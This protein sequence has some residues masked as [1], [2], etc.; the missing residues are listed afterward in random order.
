[1]KPTLPLSP[2][3]FGDFEAV[4]ARDLD[5]PAEQKSNR[6]RQSA[7]PKTEAPKTFASKIFNTYEFGYRR[8]SIE[9]PLRESY[10]FSDERISALRF[11]AGALNAAMQW[12]YKEYGSNWT[13]NARLLTN[14][15][16]LTEHA[17]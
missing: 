3:V 16:V 11:A 9:R 13:D 7:N 10:Q 14:Y 8:I 2:A 6:G 15:G 12:V 1:M 5:K 17:H 4:D